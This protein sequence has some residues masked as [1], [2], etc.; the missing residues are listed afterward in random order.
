MTWPRL[1]FWY[2]PGGEIKPGESAQHAAVRE[3]EAAEYV[4]APRALVALLH[5]LLDR[6][7]HL[8]VRRTYRSESDVPNQPG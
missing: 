3:L 4:L 7:R 5:D 2:T 8:N 1:P 6:G